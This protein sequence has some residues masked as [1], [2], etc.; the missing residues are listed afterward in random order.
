M[1]ENATWLVVV[2]CGSYLGF[3]NRKAWR[4]WAVSSGPILHSATISMVPIIE[5]FSRRTFSVPR[6]LDHFIP[7][8]VA[9]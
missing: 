4:E 9:I 1:G 5:I 7:E 3:G 8:S 6:L 2:M